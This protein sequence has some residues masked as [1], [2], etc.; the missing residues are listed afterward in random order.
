M[1]A[2]QKLAKML[3]VGEHQVEDAMHSERAAKAALSRRNLFAAAGAL[4]AGTV[5]VPVQ[6]VVL[7][8]KVFTVCIKGVPFRAAA[9]EAV[10]SLEQGFYFS[11]WARDSESLE[12]HVGG[13]R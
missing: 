6:Q 10:G 8:W 11:H 13:D 7:S 9:T 4:A 2:L 5:F 1:S 12:I 3:G